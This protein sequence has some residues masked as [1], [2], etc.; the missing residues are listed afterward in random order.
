MSKLIFKPSTVKEG[1]F[2][3]KCSVKLLSI[4]EKTQENSNGTT[5]KV[6][7]VKMDNGKTVTA[8]VYE[9]NYSFGVELGNNYAAKAIYDPERGGDLLIQMSHLI[10]GERAN[11]ND[12]D[13]EIEENVGELAAI[14]EEAKKAKL[15]K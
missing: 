9:G 6:A 14:A 13:F 5:Y 12:F 11:I 2:E 15:V 3:A 1:T 10:A 8:I 7:T 4:G